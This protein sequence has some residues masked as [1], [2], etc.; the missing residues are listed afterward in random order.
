MCKHAPFCSFLKDVGHPVMQCQEFE[1]YEIFPKTTERTGPRVGSRSE[2]NCP[3]TYKG[4]CTHCKNRTSC[5][6]P[7]PEEG[8]WHCEDYR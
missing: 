3:G 6:L 2:E 7:K 5:A 4:L 8:V 1:G